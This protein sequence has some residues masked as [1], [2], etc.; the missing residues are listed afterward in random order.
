MHYP[1]NAFA[2]DRRQNT[3][4][5]KDPTLQYTAK[6]YKELSESD[7]RQTNRMYQCN[8]IK[9]VRAPE[10]KS[11]GEANRLLG[12]AS[13]AGQ[14]QDQHQNCKDWAKANFCTL[15]PDPMLKTC[16]KSCGVCN[17]VCKDDYPDCSAWAEYGYCLRTSKNTDQIIKFMLNNC[18]KSCG[19]CISVPTMKATRKPTTT[20]PP[21]T[22]LSPTTTLP[23]ATTST[24]TTPTLSTEA[25]TTEGPTVITKGGISTPS[26]KFTGV[27][28]KDRSK[29]CKH[30]AE[31]GRCKTDRW[32]VDNC[33]L[34]CNR[35]T[36]CDRNIIQPVGPCTD[37]LG[38]HDKTIIPDNRMYAPTT[39]VPGGGWYAPASSARLYKEDDHRLK[40]VGAW[41]A[42]PRSN[43]EKYLQID[44]GNEK[45]ITALATQGRDVY[46]EHVKSYSLSFSNDGSSWNDYREG[47][48]K[49]IFDGNCDH[50]TPVLNLLEKG[51]NARYIRI[52]PIKYVAAAC[53]RVEV[54]GC[55]A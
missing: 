17:K 29:Y 23:P 5:T 47:G 53:L 48:T 1:F 20:L 9:A 27:L 21:T 4:L 3:I 22:T 15:S 24:P 8:E 42:D 30:W 16:P 10:K 11:V 19:V 14:C 49:K 28:C 32:V 13:V 40:H 45:R 43:R 12:F 25:S 18:K 36:I 26:K 52:H 41:C 54:Y 38:V 34:S 2:I 46:F 44:F 50:V 7:V 31:D 55:N 51:Q 33:L 39:F 6:P 37:I 35:S